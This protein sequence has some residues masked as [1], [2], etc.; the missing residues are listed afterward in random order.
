MNRMNVFT[1]KATKYND[2]HCGLPSLLAECS[3]CD[4]VTLSNLFITKC[5]TLCSSQMWSYNLISI[6]MKKD[7]NVQIYLMSGEHILNTQL[8]YLF[9]IVFITTTSHLRPGATKGTLRRENENS[10]FD[11]LCLITFH[12][13]FKKKIAF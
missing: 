8:G 3:H 12:W 11:V 6:V 2:F 9:S 7:I 13:S 1:N 10:F 5:I 4:S